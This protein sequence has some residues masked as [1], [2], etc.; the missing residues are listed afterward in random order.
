MSLI[1]ACSINGQLQNDA[2]LILYR[3]I[4]SCSSI[5][6]QCIV[7]PRWDSAYPSACPKGVNFPVN[8]T[9]K[10]SLPKLLRTDLMIFI[11]SLISSIRIS[12]RDK[13]SPTLF[14]ISTLCCVISLGVF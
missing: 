4:C 10:L 11:E 12:K 6:I 8:E 13:A 2:V 1:T 7:C 3:K 14:C 9:H 5:I